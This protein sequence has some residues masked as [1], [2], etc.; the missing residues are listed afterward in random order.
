MSV[1]VRVSVIEFVYVAIIAK[2]FG[3]PRE[4][5]TVGRETVIAVTQEMISGR[6]MSLDIGKDRQRRKC[7]GREFR[8]MDAAMENERQSTVDRR[9]GKR[10]SRCVDGDGRAGQRHEPADSDVVE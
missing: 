1:R 9:N 3:S 2:L 10:H 4:C 6:G 7:N 8:R 5:K